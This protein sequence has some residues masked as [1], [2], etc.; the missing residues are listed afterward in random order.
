L[1]ILGIKNK[2][3]TIH[4]FK[5]LSSTNIEAKEYPANSVI[6]A[7]SQTKGKG[8]LSR[9]WAS[10]KYKGIYFSLSMLINI[11]IASFS[12]KYLATIELPNPKSTICL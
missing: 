2:M 9:V 12:L 3:F 6:I 8:R 11:L 10:P 5:S 1:G 7:D 4:K